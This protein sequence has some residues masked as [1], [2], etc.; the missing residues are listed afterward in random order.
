MKALSPVGRRS[1]L[2]VY[3]A[4]FRIC[5]SPLF[6]AMSS[7]N[8]FTNTVATRA[9]TGVM[10]RVE[11]GVGARAVPPVALRPI[12]FS[13]V[14]KTTTPSMDRRMIGVV[15]FDFL[16]AGADSVVMLW[17]SLRFLMR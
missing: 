9:I 10:S 16:G 8:M 6:V 5:T 12:T 7:P 3:W 17:I 15:F 14:H 2:P 13:T 4:H 11:S 1:F